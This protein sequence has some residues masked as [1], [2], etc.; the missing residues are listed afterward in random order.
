MMERNS[1]SGPYTFHSV[2]EEGWLERF[3][4]M[5]GE[6]LDWIEPMFLGTYA[7]R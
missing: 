7:N 5:I 1:G 6:N 4:Q 3:F 2:Y